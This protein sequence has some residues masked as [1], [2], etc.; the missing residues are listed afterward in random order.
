MDTYSILR[1]A[2]IEKK[3]C[4]IIKVGLNEGP[5]L[6]CPYKIGIAP[7]GKRKV[8]YYQYAGYTHHNLEPDGSDAN[9]RCN[10]VQNIS[11]VE[12][13]YER[14]HAGRTYHKGPGSCLSTVDVE[15]DSA[16]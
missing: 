2:I 15:I 14:W 1:Q 16:P 8:L 6:I 12:I 7:S 4:K 5:R 13:I 10:F 9:W 11:S 3:P